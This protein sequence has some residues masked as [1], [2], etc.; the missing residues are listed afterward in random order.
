MLGDEMRQPAAQRTFLLARIL[1]GEP[2]RDREAQDA[3]A[4]ELQPL[5]RSTAGAGGRAVSQRLPQQPRFLEMVAEDGFH[6][7]DGSL[8]IRP[9]LAALG[10]TRG[11]ARGGLFRDQWIVWRMR[12]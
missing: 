5:V 2:H 9:A 1:F 12:S 7:G 4:E 11:S 3:V 6:I 8:G 10:P